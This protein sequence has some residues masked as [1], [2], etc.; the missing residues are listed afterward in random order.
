M[1]APSLSLTHTFSVQL[2]TSLSHSP[3]HSILWCVLLLNTYTF[4]VMRSSLSPVS[5]LLHTLSL[6]LSSPF[7]SQSA[8]MPS[9]LII[10]SWTYTL[11][12]PSCWYQNTIWGATRDRQAPMQ[13]QPVCR[14]LEAGMLLLL[15]H[16]LFF[17]VSFLCHAFRFLIR[18][19]RSNRFV[20]P[21][22]LL[23]CLH[24]CSLVLIN[25]LQLT[26]L[27]AVFCK[28]CWFLCSRHC[29]MRKLLPQY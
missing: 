22:Y 13:I 25:R 9:L 7:I 5:T 6:T 11:F 4:P 16:L 18:V 27:S 2:S 23:L 20:H 21:L 12:Q 8:S 10:S 28:V 14:S 1:S 24:V 17:I 19:C 15:F 3:S 26:C 29:W